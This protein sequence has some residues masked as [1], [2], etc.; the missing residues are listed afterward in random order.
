MSA[1][2]AAPPAW[3]PPYRRPS[4]ALFLPLACL[5]LFLALLVDVS[6][7]PAEIHISPAEAAT[8][9]IRHITDTPRPESVHA[10][11][12]DNIIWQFR[13]PRAV[14]AGLVGILLA[15]AGVALQGM[16]MNPLAD[17]YT[18][19]VSAGAAVGAAAAEIAG[20]SALAYG[21]AGIGCAFLAGIATVALVYWLARIGG[22][23]SAQTFLLAG[24][25]VGA[26]LWSLIP[27]AFTLAHRDTELSRIISFLI[28]SVQSADWTRAA[29]LLPFVILTAVVLGMRARELNLVTLGEE[30]AAHLGVEIERFKRVVVL[31]AAAATAAAVSVAG[32]IGFVGLVTPHLARRLVG[33]D[34]RAMLPLAAVFGAT[35]LI[36]S[37]TLV[38]VYLNERPVGV[39]T[40]IVGA[41]I[42]CL[43]LRK[44]QAPSW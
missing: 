32:I 27:L 6:M 4:I 5:V 34:H 21:L 42:F 29:L 35:L 26:M 38:R 24:V 33:P 1:Q 14:V 39:V 11:N 12:I 16:L 20:I 18:V 8:V 31:V 37:D 3:T 30:T 43:I 22:R 44:R 15:L 41:P 10:R 7:G 23:V 17:P 25:I 13:M 9:A 36:L 2:L 28:G 40:A 19:G